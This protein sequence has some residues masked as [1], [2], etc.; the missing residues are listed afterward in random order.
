MQSEIA[1]GTHFLPSDEEAFWLLRPSSVSL[2][3]GCAVQSQNTYFSTKVT[4]QV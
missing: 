3:K 1:V 4:G 2:P